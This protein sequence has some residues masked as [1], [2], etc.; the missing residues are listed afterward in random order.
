MPLLI[1][2][3]HEGLLCFF[4]AVNILPS[5]AVICS[6]PELLSDM[7]GVHLFTLYLEP[8]VSN[9][10]FVTYFVNLPL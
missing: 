10:F 1:L 8:E 5:S 9:M 6:P 7:S 4:F 2:L 3:S